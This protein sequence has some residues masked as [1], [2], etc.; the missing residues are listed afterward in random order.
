MHRGDL[1]R[2][3]PFAGV[4]D[5]VVFVAAPALR[6][7]KGLLDIFRFSPREV[8]NLLDSGRDK[9]SADSGWCMRLRFLQASRYVVLDDCFVSVTTD[10]KANVRAGTGRWPARKESGWTLGSW[11]T[12][13]I[14][15]LQSRR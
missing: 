7:R 9:C 2:G 4:G 14:S 3:F 5:A 12:A 11:R 1:G 10:G 13:A 8:L 6:R 15:L